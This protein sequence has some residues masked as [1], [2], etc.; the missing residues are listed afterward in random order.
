[1]M[2][3][4][5]RITGM[6][7]KGMWYFGCGSLTLMPLLWGKKEKKKL[8]LCLLLITSHTFPSVISL[9]CISYYASFYLSMNGSMRGMSPFIHPQVF[10]L[11]LFFTYPEYFCTDIDFT[12]LC[13]PWSHY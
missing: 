1:M 10:F 6:R 12:F 9:R 3:V 5:V 13:P 7:V 8:V 2:E 11:A 4:F